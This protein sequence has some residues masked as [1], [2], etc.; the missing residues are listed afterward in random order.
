[1]EWPSQSPDLNIIE[2]IWNY[3]K[4]EKV[5]RHISNIDE[6]WTTLQDIWKNIPQRFIDKL[7]R[8][9]PKRVN[10]VYKAK[11]HNSKY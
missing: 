7:Y 2:D 1:M 4:D 3:M 5:K 11:G 9:M 6:L 10:A 8:S